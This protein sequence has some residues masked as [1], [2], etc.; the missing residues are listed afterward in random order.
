M[1]FMP[2]AKSVSYITL[3]N[4]VSNDGFF[5][6]SKNYKV[7][8]EQENHWLYMCKNR[9]TNCCFT[10]NPFGEKR[11]IRF[12]LLIMFAFAASFSL[13]EPVT[14]RL[15]TVQTLDQP[16]SVSAELAVH[17]SHE[18]TMTVS[19]RV[20]EPVLKPAYAEQRHFTAIGHGHSDY[21]DLPYEVGWRDIRPSI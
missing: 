1:R 15:D 2:L 13:A 20:Y 21:G 11:M 6:Q 9:Y 3:V 7:T 5:S 14:E 16:V 10:L 12:M 19:G 17:A 8:I 18:R 4:K